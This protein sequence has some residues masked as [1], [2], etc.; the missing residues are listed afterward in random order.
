MRQHYPAV[1]TE[2]GVF[3]RRVLRVTLSSKME[4]AVGLEP[5]T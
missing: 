5:T 2:R 3:G 1:A 4:P